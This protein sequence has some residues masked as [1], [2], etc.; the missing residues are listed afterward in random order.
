MARRQSVRWL[1]KNRLDLAT[2]G[3]ILLSVLVGLVGNLV[4][5]SWSWA[6]LAMLV[7]L[8]V[9]LAGLEVLRHRL[10]KHEAPQ[11]QGR[12]NGPAP[13]STVAVAV[14]HQGG[15]TGDWV[16]AG[17][18]VYQVHREIRIGGGAVLLLALAAAGAVLAVGR[19]ATESDR[20]AAQSS[21]LPPGSGG[22]T[23]AGAPTAYKRTTLILSSED[24]DPPKATRSLDDA[25]YNDDSGLSMLNGATVATAPA[26]KLLSAET[27]RDLPGD[28]WTSSI[29]MAGLHPG[30]QLCLHTSD[31]RWG[32]LATTRVESD[33]LGGFLEVT[34]TV[35]T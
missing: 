3:S 7:V 18:D 32:T 20:P 12:D 13:G 8:A 24:F 2:A 30:L 1:R 22:S 10:G 4:A 5:G 11:A 15:S 14:G 21:Q 33:A 16:V 28:A 17:G 35:W 9:S 19:A 34:W 23:P 29:A 25:A 26:G 6:S 31:D 27:C